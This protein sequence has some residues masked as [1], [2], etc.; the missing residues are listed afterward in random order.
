MPFKV[1]TDSNGLQRVTLSHQPHGSSVELL[2]HGGRIVSWKNDRCEELL[3]VRSKSGRGSIFGGISICFPQIS[4]FEQHDHIRNRSWSI[5][6][7]PDLDQEEFNNTE[8][9]VHLFFKS[10]DKDSRIW[11]CRFELR[12]KVSLGPGKLTLTPSVRNIGDKPFSFTFGISNCLFVSDI[13]EV[14]VEGL[15]T[16]DFLDN[17]ADRKRFTEQAD[18]ITFDGEVN[19]VYLNT[20]SKIAVIDHGRKRTFV[21]HKQ[22]LP[23][24]GVWNPWYKGDRRNVLN[25]GNEYKTMLSVD[26]S[27]FEKQVVLKP[28]QVWKGF[29]EINAVSSSYSSGQLDPRKR[30]YYF[31]L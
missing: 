14:R 27:V 19:R 22:G 4:S 5:D 23:D 24:A 17:L 7:G 1:V 2:L 31:S 16:L 20:P 21:V 26:S 9:S 12:V 10:S 15:E 3:F 6:Y 8:S 13:S 28:F 18:A 25:L 29:Q 30:E 11:P